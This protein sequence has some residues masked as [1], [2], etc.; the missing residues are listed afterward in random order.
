MSPTAVRKLSQMKL[1]VIILLPESMNRRRKVFGITDGEQSV[2]VRENESDSSASLLRRP[3]L[4]FRHEPPRLLGIRRWRPRLQ[5][6][7]HVFQRFR[8]VPLRLQCL[9]QQELRSRNFMR[10]VY[11]DRRRAASSTTFHR[12]SC[13]LAAAR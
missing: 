13:A 10:R 6:A 7:F 1:K 3:A 8:D 4:P 9:G 5:I 12:L 2:L 11:F